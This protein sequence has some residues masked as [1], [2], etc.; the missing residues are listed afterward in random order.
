MAEA[1]AIEIAEGRVPPK[2]LSAR[3]HTLDVSALL[4][5]TMYRGQLEKR[6]NEVLQEVRSDPRLILFI[7][8]IHTIVQ[9]GAAQG[10]SLDVANMLKASLARGDVKVI[11][12][13]T[14][15]EYEEYIKS[16]AA[17]ERRFIPLHVSEPSPD[18]AI[19]ILRG[20]APMYAAHHSVD[21]SDASL[22]A[23]VL[24]SPLLPNR[25]LPD[26]AID[27]VDTTGARMQLKQDGP[28]L[29]PSPEAP[30]AVVS[31][32]QVAATVA[33]WINRPLPEVLQTLHANDE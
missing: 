16:D 32:D 33:D 21:F 23:A 30:P 29:E 8:E 4:S 25:R 22:R 18:H 26:I 17:L 5:D 28:S 20:L 12:A 3:L 31:A 11:G 1:V 6:V 15:A 10:G 24:L 14:T 13:T 7:D 9:A 2:L 27:L 19:K